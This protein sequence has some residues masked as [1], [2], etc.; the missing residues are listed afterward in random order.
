M[1]GSPL[2]LSDETGEYSSFF[3]N[4]D[5]ITGPPV[6]I[7]SPP[8]QSEHKGVIR[9]LAGPDN[10]C[11]KPF[12]LQVRVPFQTSVILFFHVVYSFYTTVCQKII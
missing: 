3:S 11:S 6:F 9:Y 2:I 8:G 7:Y 1:T 5:G 10:V 4:H 12:L